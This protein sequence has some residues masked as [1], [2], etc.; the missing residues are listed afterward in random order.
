MNKGNDKVKNNFSDIFK[1]IPG[2]SCGT[3]N[4]AMW[5]IYCNFV[6]I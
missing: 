1:N 6:K 3:K 4:F 2:L 5:G